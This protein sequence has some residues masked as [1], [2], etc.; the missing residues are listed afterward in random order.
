MVVELFLST[1]ASSSLSRARL[2]L[3]NKCSYHPTPPNSTGRRVVARPQCSN[4]A[5]IARLSAEIDQIKVS[6]ESAQSVHIRTAV[7]ARRTVRGLKT[8]SCFHV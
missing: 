5:K 3:S 7:G 8:F 1:A 6:S 4:P 2:F